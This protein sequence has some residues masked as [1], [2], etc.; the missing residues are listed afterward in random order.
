MPTT[1]PWQTMTV[2][3]TTPYITLLQGL[4]SWGLMLLFGLV[5]VE[6]FFIP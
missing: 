1:K 3:F 4:F 5:P 6:L 2:V